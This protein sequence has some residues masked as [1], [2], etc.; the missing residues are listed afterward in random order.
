[1]HRSEKIK[2]LF[3]VNS[4]VRA[5]VEEHVLSIIERLDRT[6][7]EV[8]LAC[9][10]KLID[11]MRTELAATDTELYPVHIT[12][13]KQLDRVRGLR[14]FI[15][16]KRIDIVHSHMFISSFFVSPI[17]RVSGVPVIIDTAHGREAWRTGR[18]GRSF[19]VDRFVSRFIDRVIAVSEATGRYLIE[20]KGVSAEK[21]IVIQNGRDLSRF[22]PGSKNETSRKSVG[23]GEDEFIVT[24]VGR[25]ETQKGHVYF[26]DALPAIFEKHSNL[27][28]LIVG[29]GSLCDE[30]KEQ[31]ERLGISEKVVFAGFIED[32]P[33]VLA[34]SDIVVLPSLY[35]GLPLT[36]IEA[37]AMARP[38][39]ATRVDGTPEVILDGKTGILVEPRDP[40]GLRD[41]ILELVEDEEKRRVYGE[42]GREVVIEKFSLDK[43]IEKTV[44]LYSSLYEEKV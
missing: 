35:E 21:V 11:A 18:I 24:V 14:S 28:A 25:L 5:G 44:A 43:Q 30:L 39:V 19:I 33:G 42:T 26:F 9:P 41:A 15:K 34:L 29:D 37:S 16:K 7:F 3:F 31:C 6:R 22:D 23:L 12:S 1:M 38:V 32:V 10:S 17:A 36:A 20:D 8:S 40:E 27:K 2:I 4:T 13:W